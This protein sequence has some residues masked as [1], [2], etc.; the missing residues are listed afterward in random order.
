MKQHLRSALIS[1]LAYGLGLVLGSLIS[2]W[3]AR[4]ASLDWITGGNPAIRLILGIFFLF[5]IIAIGGFIAGFSGGL[6]LESVHRPRGR[7]GYAWRSAIVL[8][9]HY[10]WLLFPSILIVSLLSF[11]NV[12]G[13][14]A[15]SFCLVFAI[16]GAIFGTLCGLFLGL[17]TVGRGL[18]W[19]PM[20]AG[21]VGFGLGGIGF[22]Y[23]LW[24]FLY[25]VNS[26]QVESSQPIWLLLGIFTFGTIGGAAF[27]F[28]YSRM[29]SEPP[30]ERPLIHPL[31]PRLRRFVL[32]SIVL[33]IMVALFR[34]LMSQIRQLLTPQEAELA[35]ILES[36]T[37]GTHWFK[38]SNLA[39]ITAMAT[40]ASTPSLSV[41]DGGLLSIAWAQRTTSGVT[42]V[43]Y[44]TGVQEEGPNH[45]RFSSP[46]NVS[47]SA[48]SESYDPQVVID[49]SGVAH[50]VW[51]EVTEDGSSD[52]L[53]SRC[54]DQ[55]CTAPVRLSGSTACIPSNIA[56][57]TENEEASIA[58]D[59]D[60]TIMVTWSNR[61][62][63]LPF[64]T[65]SSKDTAPGSPE[66]CVLEGAAASYSP[67]QARL[68]SDPGGGFRLVFTSDDGQAGEV[69]S[70]RY[71][72][73]SWET[74]PQQIGEGELPE[75]FIDQNGQTHIAW[76]HANGKIAYWSDENSR[77]APRLPC[78]SRPGI[79]QDIGGRTHLVWYSDQVE[80]VFGRSSPHT[81]LYESTLGE[82]GWSPPAI[83]DTTGDVTQPAL[84][85]DSAGT[86]HMVWTGG[87]RNQQDLYYASKIQYDCQ[88]FEL[89][90][91]SQVVYEV[92]RRET[93]RPAS[94]IVPYCRNRYD[95]LVFT[96]NPEPSYSD[97]EMKVNGGFDLMAELIRES[98]YE[99]LVSTMWY[100]KAQNHDNPGSVLAQAI[101]DLYNK[102]K[103]DPSRYPRGLTVRILLGNPPE[104][105]G[106]P[107]YV[108]EDLRQAGIDQMLNDEIGWNLEVADFAGTLPHSHTKVLIVDGKTV[109]AAGFN[110]TYD[111]LPTDH[112]SGLG[113]G[114]YDL[115]IQ[116]TGPVAQ[117]TQRA[118]DDLWS[119]AHRRHCSDLHPAVD[120]LWQATCYDF[121][122]TSDHVPEVLSYYLPEGDSTVFSMYRS[123]K[124]DE[125]DR[126]IT[127]A[128]AAA[129]HSI[130]TIQVNFTLDFICDINILLDVCTFD[131][132]LSYMQSIMEAAEN[133]GAK[134]RVLIKPFPF[135][136]IESMVAVNVLRHELEN[137]GLEDSIEIRFLLDPMHYKATL[138]DDQFLIVGSQ[139]F[140]YSAFG[141]GLG[142]TEYNLGTNDPKA[143]QDFRRLF[144]Y[145]WER[146]ERIE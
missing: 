138:I 115:G 46:V 82:D 125:A 18:L 123:E 142:L 26:G 88:G 127:E 126:Q 58:I 140:H 62:G 130:D 8:A 7:W 22:G 119:G 21:L 25:S 74:T 106:Q 31:A 67:R 114:R 70:L 37:I 96:P 55:D 90:G 98:Q 105:E 38:P 89:S 24:A 16:F 86:M 19:R 111:H 79:A 59:K 49:R 36:K 13:T 113:N 139:N 102:L 11:Y 94:D 99:V 92:A 17:I 146:A 100:D 47:N 77:I 42:D 131:N 65:W 10:G 87:H 85:S 75:V 23:G 112:Y 33:I 121:P 135:D 9:I 1:G 68:A 122:A 3:I 30:K 93:Y 35:T 32:I 78:A 71:R 48:Q 15:T 64:V 45:I 104:L 12:E 129:Q 39:G 69:Y 136:G 28:S 81:I 50:L 5:V 56:G 57:A 76:C 80:N 63:V 83:V 120:E 52:I 128:L 2:L 91:I 134:A 133:N 116:V 141:T 53:Y 137:R 66:G 109:V 60:E 84:L 95:G 6:S 107:W 110:M 29:A 117:D 54:Q 27:G 44:L 51:S 40:N 132:A 41:G 14:P 72:D 101:A 143:I 144:E 73:R 118:F 34:P 103:E 124:R 20:R 4:N 97:Q 145:H 108:L 61:S 43:Y